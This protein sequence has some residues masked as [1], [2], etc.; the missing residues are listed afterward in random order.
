[1][2]VLEHKWPHFFFFFHAKTFSFISLNKNKKTDFFEVEFF[3]L[4]VLNF[5]F[6]IWLEI[7]YAWCGKWAVMLT[8]WV[9]MLKKKN[10]FSIKFS[11]GLSLDPPLHLLSNISKCNILVEYELPIHLRFKNITSDIFCCNARALQQQD[12]G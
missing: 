1:M 2:V 9:V 5:F 12:Y 3:F 11:M 8:K 10:W 7:P 4:K 6:V